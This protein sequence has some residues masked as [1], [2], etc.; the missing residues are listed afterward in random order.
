[1]DRLRTETR[2]ELVVAS[3]LLFY[4]VLVAVPAATASAAAR[5]YEYG[6]DALGPETLA[7]LGLSFLYMAAAGLAVLFFMR[8][9][10]AAV[11]VNL[12]LAVGVL[13]LSGLVYPVGFYSAVRKTI[14]RSLPTH[15]SLVTLRGTML[16]GGS[17]S[18]YAE[19]VTWMAAAAGAAI[20][21]LGVAIRHYERGGVHE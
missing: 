11:F 4:G 10:Q 9:R 5:Y 15:Y 14:S 13:T 12:G 3:K 19:Y 18:S 8:L 17:L 1:M 16:R 7:V 21:L 20:L 2:L 6:F